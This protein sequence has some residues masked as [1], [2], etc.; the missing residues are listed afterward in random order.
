MC[1]SCEHGAWFLECDQKVSFS[2]LCEKTWN[3]QYLGFDYRKI[4]HCS[5]TGVTPLGVCVLCERGAVAPVLP[6]IPF[7]PL[8]CAARLRVCFSK[9]V[10]K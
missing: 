8:T 4:A 2:L 3:L 5:Q 1:V 10:H 7:F 9:S 6:I